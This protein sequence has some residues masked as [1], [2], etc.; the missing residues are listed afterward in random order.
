MGA[1]NKDKKDIYYSLAKKYGYRAR[2]AFKLKHIDEE[3]DIFASAKRVVDLCSAPGSWS[4]Y[5]AEQLRDKDARIL[6][7][8]VQDVVPVDGTFFMKEDITSQT[9]AAKIT[10]FFGG[11][12]AEL[13]LC[14]GAPDVTGLHDM[15]EYMQA[16]LLLAA[17]RISLEVGQCGSSF[18]GKCFRGCLTP[19]LVAHF[20]KFYGAVMLLKPRSSRSVSAECFIY[21]TGMR[22]SVCNPSKLDTSNEYEDVPLVLCGHGLDPDMEYEIREEPLVASHKPI[23]PAHEERKSS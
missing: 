7:I 16:E 17:L 4:Q 5:A 2:S 9:C 1:V 18:V 13:I 11:A 3:F 14:D 10:G 12:K 21:G 8:D 19:Y 22:D 15:D 23:P 6:S 20:R